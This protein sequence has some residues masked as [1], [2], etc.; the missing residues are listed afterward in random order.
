L[1][2]AVAAVVRTADGLADLIPEWDR[3]YQE[4]EP[5]NPFLSADWTKAYLDTVGRGTELFVVCLRSGDRLVGV[6]PLCIEQ[7]AGF[8]VLRFI[9]EDR[10]DYLGFLCASDHPAAAQQL[11][12]A[13][14]E[15]SHEW[16]LAV[17]KQLVPDYS[18]LEQLKFPKAVRSSTTVATTAPYTAADV[19][20]DELHEIG[21]HWLKRIRKRLPRFLRDG[22]ALERFTGT[23]A[24]ARLD[25]VA[26][27]EARSW[28]G[29]E[30][31]MR[32]QPGGGQ[33]LFRHAFETLGTRGEM[34]LWLASLNGRPAAY[35]IDFVLPGRLWVY[36]LGYD[37]EFQRASVGSFLCYVGIE[38]AWRGGV[39][40]YDYL[41][42]DEAYK[43][44]RTMASRTIRHLAIHPRTLRGHLAFAVLI[45]PRW[46]LKDVPIL[47]AAFRSVRNVVRAVR[48]R[49]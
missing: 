20:W 34:Q 27:V 5:R 35:K 25:Q 2:A 49:R 48:N 46:H 6:A 3:L 43:V 31:V 12:E 13:I 47:R 9:T 8:R 37:E 45:A 11:L 33:E 18:G 28:K 40:E 7:R 21:P 1:T 30:N 39:R 4:S 44:E 14:V 41:S 32:L 38:Q 42:G 19:D 24:S 15:R 17:L 10:S 22:W 16:D 29:T 36:Q 23:E 26:E